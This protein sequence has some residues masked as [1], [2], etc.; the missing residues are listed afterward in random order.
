MYVQ[1][2]LTSFRT[3]LVTVQYEC[4]MNANPNSDD[5]T[6]M[7]AD[8]VSSAGCQ[9]CA[10]SECARPKHKAY[11]SSC[12]IKCCVTRGSCAEAY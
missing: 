6:E 4:I 7:P 2:L 8:G 11:D 5:I 10:Q 9:Q 12:R 1:L 3:L